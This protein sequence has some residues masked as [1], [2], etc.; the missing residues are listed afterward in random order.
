M[1]VNGEPKTIRS[2]N[3]MLLQYGLTPNLKIRN[4]ILKLFKKLE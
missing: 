2:G 3:N 1:Y 4:I